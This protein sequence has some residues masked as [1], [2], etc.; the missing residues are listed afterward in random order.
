[1][2]D[3]R[4]TE[5][6]CKASNV[7]STT[8]ILIDQARR[9]NRDAIESL[10]ADCRPDLSRYARRH[11]DSDDVEDAVQDALV[12]IAKRI[13]GLKSLA[14]FASWAFMIVRR[15]CG[16]TNAIKRSRSNIVD[17]DAPMASTEDASMRLDVSAALALLPMSQREV[18]ILK[19]IVGLSV[20]DLA[21]HLDVTSETVKGRLHRGR[22]TLRHALADYG[23][24][25]IYQFRGQAEHVR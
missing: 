24:P 6:G 21:A 20:E 9:G 18:V 3:V 19:D 1:M 22:M 23:A 25:H 12:L 13:G 15:L 4:R 11:C 7:S 2:C 14:A 16:R 8:P 17:V 5:I 10:L